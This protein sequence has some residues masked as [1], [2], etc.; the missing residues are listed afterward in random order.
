MKFFNIKFRVGKRHITQLIE[1]ETKQKA[2]FAAGR[3][4]E[5]LYNVSGSTTADL[6]G[7]ELHQG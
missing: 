2:I 7:A 6:L 3:M 1:A 4:V 5:K